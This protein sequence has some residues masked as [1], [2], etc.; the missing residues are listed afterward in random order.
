MNE[1]PSEEEHKNIMLSHD[2]LLWKIVSSVER[3]ETTLIG[4]AYTNNKGLVHKV[5]THSE[6]IE[7]IDKRVLSLE[8]IS[9]DDENIQK[10]THS[11]LGVAATWIAAV[12]A[13]AAAFFAAKK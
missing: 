6:L 10:K 2:Q 11:F 8:T 1:K 12:A 5:D 4:N 3:I 7:S 13:V 9:E